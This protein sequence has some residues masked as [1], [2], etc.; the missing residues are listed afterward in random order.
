[1]YAQLFYKPRGPDDVRPPY[2]PAVDMW[3]AG[4]MTYF[5]L[6]GDFPFTGP[7]RAAQA[8][9]ISL[10]MYVDELPRA[11]HGCAHSY[12]VRL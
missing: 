4:V 8:Y 11:S 1:M 5:L 7:T 9:C 3:A 6:S 2:S 10:G 12:C